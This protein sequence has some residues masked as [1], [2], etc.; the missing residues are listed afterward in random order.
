[1]TICNVIMY[2]YA[3]DTVHHPQFAPN[4]ADY[5]DNIIYDHRAVGLRKIA[6]EEL[7]NTAELLAIVKLHGRDVIEYARDPDEESVFMLGA[8]LQEDLQRK[9]SL[10]LDQ[11]QD[12]ER[13]YPSTRV[14]D[15]DPM[16]TDSN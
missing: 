3:M 12:Y 4:Q 13:L 2:Q 8:Q 11:W 9:M 16:P 10:M 7:D 5:D 6:R 15:F 14:W 1:T